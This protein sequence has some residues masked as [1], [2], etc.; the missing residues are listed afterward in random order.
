VLPVLLAPTRGRRAPCGCALPGEEAR[1]RPGEGVERSGDP[2]R[3]PRQWRGAGEREALLSRSACTRL[4]RRPSA[5]GGEAIAIFPGPLGLP[6][7][8]NAGSAASASRCFS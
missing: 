4:V 7:E 5:S 6:F 1:A 2:P 8:R 3:L